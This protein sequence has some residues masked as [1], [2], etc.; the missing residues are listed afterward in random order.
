M[1]KADMLLAFSVPFLETD[2]DTWET[3]CS[4]ASW[5]EALD[6]LDALLDVTRADFSPDIRRVLDYPPCYAVHRA[7]AA[8]TFTGGLPTSAMP[9]ESLYVDED[10]AI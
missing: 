1:D 5:F 6:T 8:R 3:Y 4:P 10:A 2:E 7:F 9:V